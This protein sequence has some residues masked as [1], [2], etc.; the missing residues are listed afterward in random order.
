MIAHFFT[1]DVEEYFQVSAFESIVARSSWHEI[2]SRLAIGVMRILDL[3]DR[4]SAT[5]T[6]F[7]LG[8]LA[9]RY[10]GLVR[11]IVQGGHEIA[12][13]GWDHKRVTQLDPDAFRDEVRR[14][15]D[16]L[17]QVVGE[18]VVGY[19]APSY[20]IIPGRE[21]ALEILVE[22]GYRYDSSLFPV[23]RRGYGYPAAPRDPHWLDT[24]AGP[25]Y[26]LP[27]A[28]LRF[29]GVNLPAAGGGYFRLFPYG[30]VRRALRQAERRSASGIFYIHPW[31]L[32]PDQ[33]RL[34]VS[35]KTRIRHY[36]GLRT[37]QSR[38]RRLL[39]EFRFS[40][41]AEQLPAAVPTAA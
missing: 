6:F 14:S 41:V 7:I 3:L 20:S 39:E 27:P 1:V 4:H 23:R 22:E 17:E 12:S 37:V 32:D 25:L 34:D 16:T 30:V 38:L 40:S 36:T 18:P 5:G 10:P 24:G 28:T 13:H 2:E 19:R 9:E 33:P 35:L 26:E 11:E 21:W 31:E 15:K 8:W 29:V